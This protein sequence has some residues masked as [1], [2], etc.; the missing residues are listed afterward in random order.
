MCACLCTPWLCVCVWKRKKEIYLG[1]PFV[2]LARAKVRGAPRANTTHDNE[3]TRVSVHARIGAAGWK[4]EIE[5]EKPNGRCEVV[6]LRPKR[7]SRIYFTYALLPPY[8][9]LYT[10]VRWLFALGRESR[11]VDL[12]FLSLSLPTESSVV[13]LFVF[14]ALCG[15]G[16]C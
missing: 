14:S 13:L 3:T 11:R 5:G 15:V 8:F 16:I 6:Y 10:R 7:N 2:L 4:R 1:G 12:R 9:Q